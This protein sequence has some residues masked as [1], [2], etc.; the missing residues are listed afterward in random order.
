LW[1]NGENKNVNGLFYIEADFSRQ[2]G[3]HP[4]SSG[5]QKVA[6]EMRRF[7][8]TDETAVPWFIRQP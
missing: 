7:F 1:A 5:V 2:D 8:T 3:T 4:D 6:E